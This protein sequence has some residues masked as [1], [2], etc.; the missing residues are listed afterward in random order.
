LKVD[1]NVEKVYIRQMKRLNE[2]IVGI[3]FF[4]AMGILGYY[5]IIRSDLFDRRT[6]YYSTVIFDDVQGLAIGNKV[7][8]NGVESGTVHKVELLADG[9]IT[10]TLKMYRAFNLYTNYRILITNQSA[11]GGKIILINPGAAKVKGRIFEIVSSLENLRG[12][13]IGDPLTKISEVIDENREDI[14]NAIKNINDFSEKINKGDGT[15]SKLVNEDSLHKEAGNLVKE[16]RDTMEDS[17]EQA[18]VTSFIRALF[19]FF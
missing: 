10:V 19:T 18:P 9:E 4:C 16:A 14:R 11:L 13:S 15:I 7:F 1:R 12:E 3:V 2:I 6:Y 17:R 5:T 8:V